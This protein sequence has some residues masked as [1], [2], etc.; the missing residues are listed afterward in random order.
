MIFNSHV[1]GANHY[2]VMPRVVS[3]LIGELYY[4]ASIHPSEAS[5]LRE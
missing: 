3:E 1:C 2:L 5:K 4:K